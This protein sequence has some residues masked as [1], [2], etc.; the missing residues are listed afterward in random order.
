[1]RFPSRA[2]IETHRA[3]GPATAPWLLARL[4]S[5]HNRINLHSL[6]PLYYYYF[7]FSLNIE[8]SHH[9]YSTK[10]RERETWW[11]Q[12]LLDYGKAAGGKT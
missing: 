10:E 4:T 2:L 5:R 1:M 6:P 7:F 11:P 8:L 12:V 9:L 3:Q